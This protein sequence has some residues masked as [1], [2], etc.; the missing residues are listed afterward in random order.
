[1]KYLKISTIALLALFLI[2]P[3]VIEAHMVG[4]NGGEN[5]TVEEFDEIEGTMIRMMNGEKLSQAE[6]EEMYEFMGDHHGGYG[7]MS[8]MGGG[9]WGGYGNMMGFNS[10]SSSFIYWIFLLTTAVW[11][12]VGLMLLPLLL[13]KLNK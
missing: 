6:L 1:M 2:Q 5:V 11:L 4:T 13:K 7:M 9:D 8:M 3:I 10:S 12:L